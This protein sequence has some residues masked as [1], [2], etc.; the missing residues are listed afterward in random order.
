M[1]TTTERRSWSIIR[2]PEEGALAFA[3]LV[4]LAFFLTACAI[5]TG[6]AIFGTVAGS[7]WESVTMLPRLFAVGTGFWLTWVYL[8]LHVTH[9]QT[10]QGFMRRASVY[11]AAFAALLAA[12]TT[13]SYLIELAVYRIAGWAHGFSS[14]GYLFD[15]A[16]QVG[17][18]LLTYWLVY[19]VWTVAGALIAAA[20]RRRSWFG[21]VLSIPLGIVMIDGIE[22]VVGARFHT[23]LQIV[24]IEWAGSLP[25]ALAL[26]IGA[27][28]VGLAATWALVRDIPFPDEAR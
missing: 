21:G 3:V 24:N 22:I 20:I 1:T 10:R 25:L 4:W 14:R 9:G 2:F 28:L 19:L 13:L 23:P 27:F 11:Q 6:R 26:G 16:A 15:S 7:A 12:L 8:R 5:L 17:P 18:I